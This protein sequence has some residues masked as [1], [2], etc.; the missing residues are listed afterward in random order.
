MG[1]AFFFLSIPM[2]IATNMLTPRLVAYL[3]KR[4]LIKSNRT[5]EQ[6]IAAYRSIEAFK[7]G[8]RDKYPSYIALA[9]LS[10]GFIMGGCTCFLIAVIEHRILKMDFF[11]LPELPGLLLSILIGLFFGLGLLFLALIIT[12]ARRI[13]RFDEYTAEIREKWGED[14]V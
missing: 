13:E 1:V 7:N 14:V 5:K 10:T 3:D 2:G 8:T 4:K 12:T 6:D 9:V 11:A